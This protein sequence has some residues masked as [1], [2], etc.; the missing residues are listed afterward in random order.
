M[1]DYNFDMPWPPTVNHFHQPI[2]VYKGKKPT[3]RIIKGAKA[4]RY[5][6]DMAPFLENIGIAG[7]NIKG[8]VSVILVLH[9]PTLAKYDI[10]NR[11][12]GVFDALS[13]VGFW[14]DDEQVDILTI[15]K[16]VKIKGGLVSLIIDV[17]DE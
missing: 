12:K 15:R 8:R 7:E 9:P 11:T 16:G 3:A 2:V 5:S 1:S 14:V 17:L 4:R 6:K 13:E 10:D